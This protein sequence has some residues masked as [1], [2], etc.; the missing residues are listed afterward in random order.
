MTNARAYE[1]SLLDVG[2]VQMFLE[3]G[4]IR[5]LNDVQIKAMV[6]ILHPGTSLRDDEA[7]FYDGNWW[8]ATHAGNEIGGCAKI[9]RRMRLAA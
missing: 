8:A 7:V 5:T 1:G 3:G 6:G 4:T 2:G 9:I